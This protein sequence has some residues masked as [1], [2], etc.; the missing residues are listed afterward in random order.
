LKA[1]VDNAID[2]LAFLFSLF[3]LKPWSMAL[4]KPEGVYGSQEEGIS[5]E[6][7]DRSQEGYGFP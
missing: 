4:A 2:F 6:K 7:E 3:I 1:N 5:E